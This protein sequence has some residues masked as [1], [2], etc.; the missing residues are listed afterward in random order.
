MGAFLRA[1]DIVQKGNIFSLWKGHS[2][3]ILRVAPFAG[4][5][6]A[7]HDYAEKLFKSHS[8]SIIVMNKNGEVLVAYSSPHLKV[9]EEAIHIKKN[10]YFNKI[11]Q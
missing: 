2:T 1:K 8:G 7:A 11:I 10:N 5:S 3:T 6:Y 4:I 9:Y